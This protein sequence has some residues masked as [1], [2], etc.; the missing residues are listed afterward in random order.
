M[1]ITFS[2]NEKKIMKQILLTRKVSKDLVENIPYKLIIIWKE[3]VEKDCVNGC[4]LLT[5]N[6]YDMVLVK[7]DYIQYLIDNLKDKSTKDKIK[8][9]IKP[10]DDAFKKLLVN[11]D[12]CIKSF[13]KKDKTSKKYFWY[14]GIIKNAK[15]DLLYDL[16]SAKFVYYVKNR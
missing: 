13:S 5:I 11:K 10:S 7:R 14:W 15:G 12:I 8:K 1:I 6:D 9:L 3:F 4:A 16:K 2:N